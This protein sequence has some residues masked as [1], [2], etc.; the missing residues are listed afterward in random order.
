M[1]SEM[2]AAKRADI[3]VVHVPAIADLTK[4]LSAKSKGAESA[5][6]LGAT[7]WRALG[8]IDAF[9]ESEQSKLQLNSL[10]RFASK[11]ADN[12][13]SQADA[14]L[15]LDHP[16][17]LHQYFRIRA[18]RPDNIGLAGNGLLKLLPNLLS[19]LSRAPISGLDLQNLVRAISGILKDI[20][21]DETFSLEKD[22][23]SPTDKPVDRQTGWFVRWIIGHQIHALLNHFAAA[24]IYVAIS[25]VKVNDFEDAIDALNAAARCIEAFSP[26]RR[27][28]LCH[29]PEFYRNVLRPSITPPALPIA[30]SGKMHTEYKEFRMSI[31]ELINDDE[32][33]FEEL[34]KTSPSLAFAREAVLEAD[35]ADAE[36]H[37]T[38]VWGM[39]GNDKSII[40]A[41]QS[42]NNALTSLRLIRNRRELEFSRFVRYST[43]EA[44]RSAKV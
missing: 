1:L 41:P 12:I 43:Q 39:I 2:S 18:A 17:D 15:Y 31:K 8:E 30:L 14:T 9:N 20:G 6:V 37:V 34:V 36:S 27:L 23:A 11:M 21:F 19:D 33:S 13:H 26:A 5:I 38:M 16:S 22:D 4:L 25:R 10:A 35:L 28:S 42:V 29:P 7:L 40:Q 3:P 24:Y 44:E 32:P